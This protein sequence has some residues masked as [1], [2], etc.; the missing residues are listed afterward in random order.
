MWRHEI[1]LI[2]KQ[3]LCIKLVKYWDK[4]YHVVEVRRDLV[5]C[6]AVPQEGT[7]KGAI[8]TQLN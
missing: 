4:C 5:I 1:K 7:F 3:T 2:V 8:H 6:G